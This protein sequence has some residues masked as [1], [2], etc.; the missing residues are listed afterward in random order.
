MENL[1]LWGMA[2]KTLGIGIWGTGV[3]AEFHRN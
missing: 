1:I 2:I 3:I